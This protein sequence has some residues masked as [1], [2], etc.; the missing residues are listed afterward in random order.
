MRY[1]VK[2]QKDLMMKKNAKYKYIDL[3]WFFPDQRGALHQ[4]GLL[5]QVVGVTEEALSRDETLSGDLAQTGRVVHVVWESHQRL[6][7][8]LVCE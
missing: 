1:L 6:D 7:E 4:D 2:I 5:Q 8:A 3:H